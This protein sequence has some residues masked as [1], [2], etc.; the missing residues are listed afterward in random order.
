MSDLESRLQSGS[1]PKHCIA[2]SFSD[3]FHFF[4]VGLGFKGVLL[5]FWVLFILSL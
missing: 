5:K 3:L 4:W 2:I 1:V